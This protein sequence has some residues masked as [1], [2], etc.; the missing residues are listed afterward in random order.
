MSNIEQKKKFVRIL[1]VSV[2]S[3]WKALCKKTRKL[4]LDLESDIKNINKEKQHKTNEQKKLKQFN[5]E[6]KYSIVFTYITDILNN[7]KNTT[8][9][10]E[11][12][13]DLIEELKKKEN[14]RTN[15][16]NSFYNLLYN[17]GNGGFISK[18]NNLKN[19]YEQKVNSISNISL[20]LLNEIN[21]EKNKLLNNIPEK[22]EIKELQK[23]IEKYTVNIE[24]NQNKLNEL[25][26]K[27][28][29][30]N[31]TKNKKE[32]NFKLIEKQSDQLPQGY[33]SQNEIQKNINTLNKLTTEIE[34]IDQRIIEIKLEKPKIENQ[35]KDINR[36]LSLKQGELEKKQ[37]SLNIK[38]TNINENFTNFIQYLQ[39]KESRDYTNQAN[40]LELLQDNTKLRNTIS[41]IIKNKKNTELVENL[42][43]INKIK[44]SLD[45][46]QIYNNDPRILLNNLDYYKYDYNKFFKNF[47]GSDFEINTYINFFSLKEETEEKKKKEIKKKDKL[48]NISTENINTLNKHYDEKTA[49]EDDEDD[50]NKSNLYDFMPF[51]IHIST[52]KK[53]TILQDNETKKQ[54]KL[55]EKL[56][57]EINKNAFELIE[58]KKYLYYTYVEQN[59]DLMKQINDKYDKLPRYRI[60]IIEIIKMIDQLHQKIFKLLP[61][62]EVTEFL[63][64]ENEFY[65]SIKDCLTLNEKYINSENKTSSDIRGG[66]T[67]SESE[68][69]TIN[70]L[71][72]LQ[73]IHQLHNLKLTKNFILE[74][75]QDS[76]K[77]KGEQPVLG[78]ELKPESKRIP[79]FESATAENTVAQ[80]TAENTV[81]Q[82]ATVEVALESS[83]AQ[84]SPASAAQEQSVD[85]IRQAEEQASQAV[86]A[87]TVSEVVP[88]Q[89]PVVQEESA[90]P[91]PAVPP[92][93][94]PEL[95]P[96]E[97]A[98]DVKAEQSSAPGQSPVVQEE[99]A[100]QAAA[101]TLQKAFRGKRIRKI[102]EEIREAEKELKK[103]KETQEKAVLKIQTFIRG[104]IA[105]K[106]L[107]DKREIQKKA[108]EDAAKA[109]AEEVKAEEELKKLEAQAK[110]E[111]KAEAK[112]EAKAEVQKQLQEAQEELKQATAKADKAI[113]SENNAKAEVQ[114][115]IRN[116]QKEI[117]E[118]QN[119]ANAEVQKQLKAE[120]EKTERLNGE[121]N[122]F[123]EKINLAKVQAKAEAE[124]AAQAEIQAAK[125]ETEEAQRQAKAAAQ[126]AAAETQAA[127]EETQAAQAET[128]AAQAETK[129]AQAKTEEAQTKTEE[130][131]VDAEEKIKQLQENTNIINDFNLKMNEVFNNHMKSLSDAENFEE[132]KKNLEATDA[133]NPQKQLKKILYTQYFK[134]FLLQNNNNEEPSD[135]QLFNYF[136]EFI[137]FYDVNNKDLF[138]KNYEKS[139]NKNY[140]NIYKEF[141]TKYFRYIYIIITEL[142]KVFRVK[143]NTPD[144]DDISNHIT[145]NSELIT[146]LN[147]YLKLL[148][149]LDLCIYILENPD[150]FLTGDNLFNKINDIKY[151]NLPELIKEI[152]KFNLDKV[153]MQLK[154]IYYKVNNNMVIKTLNNIFQNNQK[155]IDTFDT[156]VQN[157]FNYFFNYDTVNTDDD[158]TIYEI[159]TRINNL[160]NE[161]KNKLHYY[162]FHSFFT[163]KPK[164]DDISDID[165]FNPR[166]TGDNNESVPFDLNFVNLVP[167][168]LDLFNNAIIALSDSYSVCFSFNYLNSEHNKSILN[169]LNF[170]M[171]KSNCGSILRINEF[172]KDSG[173]APQS[174]PYGPCSSGDRPSELTNPEG[175]KKL[176]GGHL[177]E[178]YKF[179]LAKHSNSSDNEDNNQN[180]TKFAVF[181]QDLKNMNLL[182]EN[183]NILND[184]NYEKKK[185][186]TDEQLNEQIWEYIE[187]DNPNPKMMIVYGGSGSGKTYLIDRFINNY[188]NYSIDILKKDCGIKNYLWYFQ[189]GKEQG[190]WRQVEPD[191]NKSIK[192]K[193]IRSTPQNDNSSR[194]HKCTYLENQNLYIFDLCGAEK[195]LTPE[196]YL[197]GLNKW[198]KK[199]IIGEGPNINIT[200][201]ASDV[202]IYDQLKF[203]VDTEIKNISEDDIEK[204]KFNT[205]KDNLVENFKNLYKTLTIK[206]SD[207]NFNPLIYIYNGFN[208]YIDGENTLNRLDKSNLISITDTPKRFI[209]DTL[210]DNL[211]DIKKYKKTEVSS[212]NTK[213]LGKFLKLNEDLPTI[214]TSRVIK[215]NFDSSINTL[216]TNLT[217]IFNTYSKFKP[218]S[219]GKN[220][221]AKNFKNNLNDNL[222]TLYKLI[223]EL[224]IL[225]KKYINDKM[226]SNIQKI[227]DDITA[228]K[229]SFEKYEK[230]NFNSTITEGKAIYIGLYIYNLF[231]PI[232]R[233]LLTVLDDN[234]DIDINSLFLKNQSQFNNVVDNYNNEIKRISEL[235]EQN[236]K[237]LEQYQKITKT[238]EEIN[239]CT[240]VLR[241]AVNKRIKESININESLVNVSQE[242]NIF[243]SK[244]NI[245]PEMLPRKE[246][247]NLEYQLEFLNFYFNTKKKNN[248]SENIKFFVLPTSKEDDTINTI[249]IKKL[250]LCALDSKDYN[251][252]NDINKFDTINNQAKNQDDTENDQ[253]REIYKMN[254]NI[255]NDVAKPTIKHLKVP[256]KDYNFI[257]IC[258]EII[259]LLKDNSYKYLDIYNDAIGKYNDFIYEINYKEE[260][261]NKYK[262]KYFKIVINEDAKTNYENFIKHIKN[263]HRSLEWDKDIIGINKTQETIKSD[264]EA[265]PFK[266]AIQSFATEI[267]KFNNN[268]K[269]KLLKNINN[270]EETNVVE[271]EYYHKIMSNTYHNYNK[272]L[273]HYNTFIQSTNSYRNYIINKG[274]DVE[275]ERLNSKFI[276]LNNLKDNLE[277]SEKDK[278]PFNYN[279]DNIIPVPLLLNNFAGS[280][281]YTDQNLTLDL[282]P[283]IEMGIYF[284]SPYRIID[285]QLPNIVKLAKFS[286]VLN[287]G[288]DGVT[289]FNDEKEKQYLDLECTN[290]DIEFKI[291]YNE[292]IITID[293][294][295]NIINYNWNKNDWAPAINIST[296]GANTKYN[297]KI[298]LELKRLKKLYK[299]LK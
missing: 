111:A 104:T 73:L 260:K 272:L 255:Y 115:E 279:N 11:I 253:R 63:K 263:N 181:R 137:I 56:R 251:L 246:L 101:V 286:D 182:L 108:E 82:A 149:E 231:V 6:G 216:K 221:K 290:D 259:K 93:Q 295:N 46:I 21:T 270:K 187:K 209:K 58:F 245:K 76:I 145:I 207:E 264:N 171:N 208:N 44:E 53:K 165:Q 177:N 166:M 288:C 235:E 120:I 172:Q 100:A 70:D 47:N 105:R 67:E 274:E 206:Q 38:E 273:D 298:R 204:Y 14:E 277:L 291:K 9:E 147:N 133:D 121:I 83:P 97:A 92:P 266:K 282:P 230:K 168:N 118:G 258:R 17:E 131:Q 188:I 271:L 114:E 186:L 224:E 217:N 126:A 128:Q 197:K 228:L 261:T 72:V 99:S 106:N 289:S 202:N 119:N 86:Q 90:A 210:Y 132:I 34:N 109:K 143:H 26:L 226:P 64:K 61:D 148:K 36:N 116:L 200:G 248:N 284:V 211:I 241:L 159:I 237:N 25:D 65:E 51:Y 12:M 74:S 285:L 281:Q 249:D 195:E 254:M 2:R 103:K 232:K 22:K 155:I 139:N 287:I 222:N 219:W 205:Y 163:K 150:T 57:N 183:I 30:Y 54:Y 124:A 276:Y 189:E 7:L 55:I 136:K 199:D 278:L 117:Q 162:I 94:E 42:E 156:S 49:T 102:L 32:D 170:N 59:F 242:I 52:L 267:F 41:E 96:T 154:Y 234:N 5:T 227:I 213:E 151:L 247:N 45:K 134:N 262:T 40:L 239:F 142:R 4:Q 23:I 91:A 138:N 223:G 15:L 275:N 18:I 238:N 75:I 8:S 62:E 85:E 84:A 43:S 240:I 176:T 98:A 198:L 225:K 299:S 229:T 127:Q 268:E 214:V 88:E 169:N 112:E 190:G 293:E 218:Y 297:D 220:E 140:E 31:N 77:K 152:L 95:E 193:I 3:L 167:F 191:N 69:K 160:T 79:V 39:N 203:D 129:A 194:Q 125:A 192:E 71:N 236:N 174:N 66:G 243:K 16:F 233:T 122:E 175:C 19:D 68:K 269:Y 60:E 244:N 144:D 178:Y 141:Y 158:N 123:E 33:T 113:E 161:N 294:K 280:P 135:E 180:L 184:Y 164:Q 48:L 146:Y 179:K 89:P 157:L 130:A 27:L 283:T 196:T 265:D 13:N 1:E 252:N 173:P 28:I 201:N 153:H 212:I 185:K 107:D 256:F 81:E 20:E 80:A 50:L 35:N 250:I 215:T 78:P 257:Q 29:N 110:A 37:T 10:D 296:G 87:E 24:N 292:N